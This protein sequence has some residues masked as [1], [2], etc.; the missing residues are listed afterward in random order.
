M[1]QGTEELTLPAGCNSMHS[2][3]SRL[4]QVKEPA[5]EPQNP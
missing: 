2:N 1:D 4:S 3:K 5:D